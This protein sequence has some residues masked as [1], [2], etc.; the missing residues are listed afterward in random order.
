MQF[1]FKFLLFKAISKNLQKAFILKD[2]YSIMK[3][4]PVAALL[5]LFFG[6]T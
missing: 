4:L 5:L 6:C 3:L 1:Y 2:H